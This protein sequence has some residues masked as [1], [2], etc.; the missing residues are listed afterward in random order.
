MPRDVEEEFGF[1]NNCLFVKEEEICVASDIHIGLED[2]MLRQGMFFPLNEEDALMKRLREVIRAFRPN[3]FILNGDVIHSFDRIGRRVG[4]K[5]ANIMK[6]LEIKCQVILIRGSHDT[7]L[8]FLEKKVLDRYDKGDFTFVHGDFLPE[9]HGKLVLGHDHPMIEIEMEKMPCFLWGENAIQGEDLMV[10]P[11][12]N[13][14]CSGTI[15]NSYESRHFLSPILRKAH[16]SELSPIVEH[17]GEVFVF[18]KLKE[19]RRH[20]GY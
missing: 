1:L 17:Q 8:S 19:L 10:T 12:F 9:D 18:P 13:P 4:D 2:M 14:L 3:T 16:T 6:M 11:A 15:I 7:M 5:F 20:M